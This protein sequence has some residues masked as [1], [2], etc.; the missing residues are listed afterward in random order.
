MFLFIIHSL[1]FILHRLCRP[2]PIGLPF[3]L[4]VRKS[5]HHHRTGQR[6]HQSGGRQPEKSQHRISGQT[7]QLPRERPHITPFAGQQFR[8]IQRGIAQENRR[9]RQPFQTQRA[10]AERRKTR[11]D[12]TIRKKV[13]RKQWTVKE[14]V[15]NPARKKTVPKVCFG[16]VFWGVLARWSDTAKSNGCLCCGCA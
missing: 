8:E 3:L 15:D 11:A 4:R 14:L 2:Q 6:I 9:R 16:T 1:F 13:N 10:D 12:E 5:G 7:W